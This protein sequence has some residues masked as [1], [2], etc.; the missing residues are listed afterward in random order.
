MDEP[1]KFRQ[2]EYD[3][4]GFGYGSIFTGAGIQFVAVGIYMCCQTQWEGLIAILFGALFVCF[5][6]PI[7]IPYWR[8][9]EISADEIS[10]KLGFILLWKIPVSAI[11]GIGRSMICPS[12]RG[13]P[14]KAEII[15]LS[16]QKPSN[17]RGI[18]RR[19]VTD[20]EISAIRGSDV[21]KERYIMQ[22]VMFLY[23]WD[24]GA[25]MKLSKSEGTWMEYTPER[26]TV[27]K[28]LFPNT[29]NY[30]D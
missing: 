29:E 19:R 28:H 8:T 25:N 7:M 14:W 13:Q 15:Y 2:M 5:G 30:I 23:F 22:R 26:A 12:I 4:R 16:L 20:A 21:E 27:L 11:K 3:R 24:R 10:L 18:E 9:L 1:V 6:L 17:I